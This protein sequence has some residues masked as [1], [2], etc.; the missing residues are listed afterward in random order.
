MSLN[1]LGRF[2]RSPR[3][4][5]NRV[6]RRWSSIS[7]RPGSDRVQFPGAVNSKFTTEMSF[8][9]PTDLPS[10]PTFRVMN[11]DGE[12]LDP[13][14]KPL[15]VSNEEILTWYK[16]MLAV[17][18][19]DVV[20]F[21]AQRQGRLS[22]Y[23]VSA[24]EEG[25]SVGSAAALTPDDV[26]F[27]QYRETGVFQQRGFTLK[28]FMSQLFANCN[29]NG[30]G[31]N[32]PVH[33]GS[34][35]P[36]IHAISSPLATQ[37]P[38]ASGAAYA[39]K[40]QSLQNPDIPP[41]IVAC[42]F[43]EGAASEGDFH[44]GLNIAATRSSPVVFICR[45]NGYAISTPTLEQYRGDGI[46][47]RGVG[48]GIDTIRVDGNDIFAVYEAMQEARRIALSDGGRP[49]LIEA[50]SYRVSHHSTSDDSFAYRARVEVEDWKRRD[51]PII[52]LR[53]WLENQGLWNEDL[54]RETRDK[55]RKDVL[56]AFGEAEREKKPPIREAF[57]DVYEEITEEAEA[58]M[59]ELKRILETYPD[60]Y[61]LRQ[62][63]DGVK[64]I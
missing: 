26:V 1:L 59:K 5:L 47:S 18:V 63:Q 10:I 41:R 58:Q 19:M 24:G 31:R 23:M 61:D 15:G 64:G 14:R 45:N 16:N 49:V 36:R 51:N 50:M 35:Y 46:A 12:L 48:Y 44:A 37:I 8:I 40:L 43:G 53:K 25:I 38:Q 13:N 27:A 28:D 52:R 56:K 60:E 11:S 62:Y 21:E 29:D 6:P 30:R 55:M 54:E 33:Y 20:M 32:M 3:V 2:A 42:Y 22:F 57:T 39:L 34:K 7:Q 9:N 4:A 17:S